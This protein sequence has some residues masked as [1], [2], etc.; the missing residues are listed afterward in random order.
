M[1]FDVLTLFPAMFD[2]LMHVGVIGRAAAKRVFDIEVHNLRDWADPPHYVVDDAPYGGGGGMVMKP[3]PVWRALSAVRRQAPD[4]RVVLTTPQGKTFRQQDAVA[5]SRM[6]G[7]IFLCGRYE[8]VDERI[9]SWVDEEYSIGDYVLTGGEYAALVMVD[10]IARLVPGV[11]GNDASAEDDSFSEGLLEYPHYTRPVEFEG[12]TVP[13]VLVS[14]NH[15]EIA[16]WR[17]QESLRRTLLRRPDLLAKQE[18]DD[19]DRRFVDDLRK[20]NA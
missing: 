20:G 7:V 5:F 4:S 3:E 12:M 16:R 13:S 14:G 2:P 15:G 19:A 9:R 8:G 10:A 6:A 11:L 18:L 1:R 17:R